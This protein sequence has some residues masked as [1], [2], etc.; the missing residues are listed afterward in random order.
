MADKTIKVKASVRKGKIVKGYNR[1][2][3]KNTRASL[4]GLSTLAGAA[5]GFV[6]GSKLGAS[7]PLIGGLMGTIGG[8]IAGTVAANK[9][10][11]TLFLNKEQKK[12]QKQQLNKIQYTQIKAQGFKDPI[13]QAAKSGINQ[14]ILGGTIAGGISLT[15]SDKKSGGYLR[16]LVGGGDK[17]K[18]VNFEPS[19]G[20]RYRATTVTAPDLSKMDNKLYSKMGGE[21]DDN[22]NKKGIKV[23]EATKQTPKADK[24][25]NT[26][27][28]IEN[29]VSQNKLKLG[30]V[31]QISPQ[32]LNKRFTNKYL[33]KVA[34]KARKAAVVGAVGLGT[35]SAI[36]T[37]L[38]TKD[39]NKKYKLERK[40]NKVT[41][42]NHLAEFST[43]RVTVKSSIR[44]GKIVKGYDRDQR[45]RVNGV[46][47]VGAATIGTGLAY[48]GIKSYLNTTTELANKPYTD[49]L[50]QQKNYFNEPT[51]VSNKA[52]AIKDNYKNKGLQQLNEYKR[53][54]DS[55]KN[56]T[57][58]IDPGT[59]KPNSKISSLA[60]RDTQNTLTD[61]VKKVLLQN[62]V[63]EVA[64]T[65]GRR[66]K[67]AVKL[68]Q[69]AANKYIKNI[70]KIPKI[71]NKVTAIGLA[72]LIGTT[73][74]IGTVNSVRKVI[75]NRRSRKIK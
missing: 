36:K 38:K 68:E 39:N 6:A 11:S 75:N 59:I 25:W 19:A 48:K 58:V 21:L 34:I 8:T 43:K 62:K 14:A 70:G 29:Y 32:N 13:Q 69:Q 7:H 67:V 50:R 26:T 18:I 15:L 60:I 51:V 9:L 28:N 41:I 27:D 17:K 52:N 3:G 10:S 4:V 72:G 31:N 37:Y 22:F 44:K 71:S 2:K 23:W 57:D 45:S 47:D 33:A 66:A 74:G 63:N 56:I 42:P 49:S 64:S 55:A 24:I 65:Q 30:E 73:V 12:Q 35:Y 16:S 54:L 46:I 61:D 53:K 20:N 1:S 5:G 40:F